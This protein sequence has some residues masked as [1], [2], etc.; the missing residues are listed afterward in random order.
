MYYVLSIGSNLGDRVD[1]IKKALN[2]LQG[3]DVSV[4]I[5]SNIYE[6]SPVDYTK[7][8]NFYNMA[9]VVSCKFM[10]DAL[11]Q[12]IKSIELHLKRERN[13]PKGPR[14]IDID[15]IFWSEGDYFSKEIT[16]PHAEFDKRL[17]VLVPVSE[18]LREKSFFWE[19]RLY[20]KR[21]IAEIKK[22][23]PFQTIICL[24]KTSDLF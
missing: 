17:F 21:K 7:Q 23:E 3:K 19:E 12:I 16:I 11:L 1:N 8:D 6:T 2:L 5:L 10:P 14:T 20:I 4:D 13:I 22:N 9:I 24:G 18:V 15:I